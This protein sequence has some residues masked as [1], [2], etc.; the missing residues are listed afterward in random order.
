M[1]TRAIRLTQFAVIRPFAAGAA[2]RL[3][4][5]VKDSAGTVIECTAIADTCLGVSV[6]SEDGTWPAAAADIVGVALLGTDA[7]VPV[8]VGTTLI[9]A[10]GDFVCVDNA[11]ANG[12][13][14]A[15]IGGANTALI[16]IGQALQSGAA[17]DLVGVNLACGGPCVGS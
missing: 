8:L 5:P 7:V 17:A 9:G 2:V 16:V 15:T 11:A 12:S 3:G 1:A 13:R 6:E 4:Y 14:T 10:V